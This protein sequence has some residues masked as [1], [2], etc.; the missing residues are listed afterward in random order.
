VALAEHRRAQDGVDVLLRERDQR[1]L[2]RRFA[3]SPVRRFA[4]STFGRLIRTTGSS[5]M[6]GAFC[7][8]QTKDERAGGNGSW[9]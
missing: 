2:V 5:D 9:R 7:C 8:E 4:G 1:I 6:V 3:G